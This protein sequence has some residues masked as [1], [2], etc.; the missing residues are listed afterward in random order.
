MPNLSAH[1]RNIGLSPEAG[2][3]G[4]TFRQY[5]IG[6]ALSYFASTDS[7][8]AFQNAKSAIAHADEVIKLL[9]EESQQNEAH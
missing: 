6:Q 1:I 2:E 9:A 5:L 3:I 7:R 8:Y 4:M